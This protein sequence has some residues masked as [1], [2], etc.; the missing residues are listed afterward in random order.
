VDER[1]VVV[2]VKVITGAVFELA[3]HTTGVVMRHVVVV[4]SVDDPPVR[5]LVL[6]VTDDPLD[7]LR[8]LHFSLLVGP[9]GAL[10]GPR[11]RL[12][13]HAGHAVGAVRTDWGLAA[14]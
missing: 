3:E 4:V 11:T 8:L 5:M 2:L 10:D 12:P 14:P 13:F 9:A 7:R 6:L 1:G